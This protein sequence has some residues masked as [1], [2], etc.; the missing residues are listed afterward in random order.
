M[1][2]VAEIEFRVADVDAP[3]YRLERARVYLSGTELRMT[4]QAN[5]P[6]GTIHFDEEPVVSNAGKT[7]AGLADGKP[8][9]VKFSTACGC[10]GTRRI[11][12]GR[13]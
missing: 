2:A 10:K 7:I 13:P 12:K 1:P 9:V 5:T 8:V 4:N 3:T 6:M 11:P